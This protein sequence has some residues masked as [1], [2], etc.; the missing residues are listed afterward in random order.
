MVRSRVKSSLL[1]GA[2]GAL[3]YLALVQ[4]YALAVAPLRIGIGAQVAVAAAV[5]VL[6]A[7][8]AYAAERRLLRLG[9]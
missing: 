8:V 1:W 6:V 2:V 3:A 9:R 7:A 5:G 4:G